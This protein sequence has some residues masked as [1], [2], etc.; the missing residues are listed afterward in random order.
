MVTPLLGLVGKTNVGKSA[1][2]AAA[3][4]VEVPSENRPFVTI[5]PHV[6]VAYLRKRCVHPELGLEKCDPMDGFCLKGWRFI[7]VKLVDVAGLVPGASEGR[8]LGTQFLDAVR[9]ADA[10]LIVVDASGSTDAEG[11]PVP[12]GT[13][14][15]REDVRILLKEFSGWMFNQI[16][17]DWKSFAMRVDTSGERPEEALFQRLSGFS[18]KREQIIKALE[19]LNPP[20]KL[21][22]WSE[23]DLRKF[24]EKLVEL[25]PKV[26]VANKVDVEGAEKGVE[27]LKE[28]FPYPVIPTSA[29]AE[30]ILRKAAKAGLIE[31]IP[32]DSD[33][34][35]LKQLDHKQKKVLDVIRKKVLEKWGSTG[36]VQALNEAVFNQL[37]M[38]VV[39][40]V[41]DAH[42]FTDTEGRVLPEA[43]LVP[44]GTTVKEFAASIHTDLA[45]GFLYAIDAKTGRKLGADHLVED[46]MILK[47]VSAKR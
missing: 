40:P 35:E 20:S 38:V 44:R 41:H 32:G 31:Y 26:I 11:N 5:E 13:H 24:I 9:R 33:F 42:K 6:G 39:Y 30:L 46:N 43:R 7:P 23:D 28:E 27:L 34:K 2:F 47:I 12:P 16:T 1:F 15:P 14:D 22:K 3:T 8:G 21:S 17:K 29:V 19:E 10:L 37:D 25:R 36:V 18:V 45:K 4:L